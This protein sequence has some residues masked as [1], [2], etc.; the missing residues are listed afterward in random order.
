M[1]GTIWWSVLPA[2]AFGVSSAL[3]A[4]VKVSFT[5]TET[6][7]HQ[8]IITTRG[9]APPR[10]LI[11]NINVNTFDLLSLMSYILVYNKVYIYIDI[12]LLTEI[13]LSSII[14]IVIYN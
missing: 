6:Y 8:R 1:E 2:R 7:H 12:F 9:A 14:Y 11:S 13:F 10:P 4:E 5:T 3:D